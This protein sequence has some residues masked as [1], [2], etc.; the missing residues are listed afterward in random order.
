MP[1]ENVETTSALEQAA[2]NK[3]EESKVLEQAAENKDEDA[4]ALEHIQQALDKSEDEDEKGDESKGGDDPDKDEGKPETHEEDEDGDKK[5]EKKPEGGD[6]PDKGKDEG[7]K[8]GEDE[9]KPPKDDGKPSDDK[10]KA[11]LDSGLFDEFR[12]EGSLTEEGWG[13]LMDGIEALLNEVVSGRDKLREISAFAERQKSEEFNA[14]L[15]SVFEGL[16]DEFTDAFGKGSASKLDKAFM[17]NRN[18]VLQKAETLILG[19]QAQG[20][21]VTLEDAVKEAAGLFAAQNFRQPKER[22]PQQDRRSQFI[23]K[24]AG[25]KSASPRGDEAA[26]DFIEKFKKDHND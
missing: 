5:P 9:A 22:K 16:G 4:K 7:K 2:E 19:Y 10:V 21:D 18:Q 6:D 12:K 20:K 14:R 15:D 26:L 17:D 25:E 3:N 24:P 1:G 23:S 11:L 13:K 8:D